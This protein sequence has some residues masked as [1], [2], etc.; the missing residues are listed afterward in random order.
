MILFEDALEPTA[1]LVKF[2]ASFETPTK[3]SP[4][5]RIA[6]RT[7]MIK[8]KSMNASVYCFVESTI[9]ALTLLERRFVP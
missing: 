4:T 8:K 9:F 6:M 2:T 7:T 3:R 5:P 1:E